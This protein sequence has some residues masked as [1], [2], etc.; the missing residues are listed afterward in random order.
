[1]H[2]LHTHQSPPW[3]RAL[4]DAAGTIAVAIAVFAGVL[5]LQAWP[6]LTVPSR[7][8]CAGVTA[9]VLTG[10]AIHHTRRR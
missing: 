4:N 6:H 9:L 7:L 2:Q 10:F 5:L 1:M 8:V 3:R